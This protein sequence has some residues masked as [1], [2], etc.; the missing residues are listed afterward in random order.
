[1]QRLVSVVKF[2]A[3]RGLAL[4]MM[5]TLDRP[6]SFSKKFSKLFS[7]KYIFKKRC[8]ASSDWFCNSCTNRFFF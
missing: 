5:K 8:D 7:S 1:M 6:E 2:I 3:E 4:G